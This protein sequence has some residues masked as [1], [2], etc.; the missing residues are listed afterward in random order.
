MILRRGTQGWERELQGARVPFR[1]DSDARYLDCDDAFT[2]YA[3]AAT[4][5]SL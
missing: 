4:A 2:M 1:S 3:A 5:K